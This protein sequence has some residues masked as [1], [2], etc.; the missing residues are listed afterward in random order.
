MMAKIAAVLT[1]LR[2]TGGAPESMLYIF[3]DMNMDLWT[4]VRAILIEADLITIKGHYITLTPL[5][6]EKADRLNAVITR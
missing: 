1:T 6:T 2:D 5:G 3:F 4:K